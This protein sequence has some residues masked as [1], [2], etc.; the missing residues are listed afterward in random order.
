[1]PWL[2]TV[3]VEEVVGR[4]TRG[5]PSKADTEREREREHNHTPFAS[6]TLL[7]SLTVQVFYC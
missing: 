2:L 6:H 1:M 3:K 5:F 4:V 7:L